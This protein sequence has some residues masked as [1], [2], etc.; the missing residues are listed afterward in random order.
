MHNTLTIIFHHI[1]PFLPPMPPTP[2]HT[3]ALHGLTLAAAAAV[4]H[5]LYQ[6]RHH[7]AAWWGDLACDALLARTPLL[8]PEAEGLPTALDSPLCVPVPPPAPPPTLAHLHSVDQLTPAHLRYL[9]DEADAM[10]AMVRTRGRCDRLRGALL[11]NV[12]YEPSTRTSASFHAAM[13]RL[14]GGVVPVQASASSACKGESLADT[15]RCLDRYCDVVVLRHPDEGSAREAADVARVPVLNAGD[16]VGEHPTQALLDAYTIRRELRWG[17]LKTGGEAEAKPWRVTFVG[18]LKQG[19][20]VHSLA[21]LLATHFHVTLRC[22]SPISLRMP[23]AVCDAVHATGT[24]LVDTTDLVGAL[25]ETDVLY[26]TRIQKERFATAAE[27]EAVQGAYRIDASVLQALPATGVVM[28]PLPRVD[29]LHTD[30]DTD[31]RA[32]YFRQ[33]EYGLHVRMALL[34]WL[35]EGAV[36]SGDNE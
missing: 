22:V 28:H 30:V 35:V 26:V 18:D 36:G 9:F 13:L 27:Y 7:Y 17:G 15:V 29:E 1:T 32:A 5:H 3:L 16:G 34:A 31:P 6:H 21:K 19:R 23:D 25:A 4:A 2:P 33:M 20:T 24:P 14:G 8:Q 10:G 12:F 11:A